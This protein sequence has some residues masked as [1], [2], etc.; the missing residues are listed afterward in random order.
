MVKLFNPSNILKTHLFLTKLFMIL[1]IAF[2]GLASPNA[3]AGD[4][5]DD[6][7]DDCYYGDR[8]MRGHSGRRLDTMDTN[9]DKVISRSEFDAVHNETFKL[10]DSNNDGNLSRSEIRTHRDK[11]H[12]DNDY[13]RKHFFRD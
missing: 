5:Y 13:R 12:R 2:I 9:N 4:D 10:I 8:M 11:L 3:N 6:Y 7:D 1:G